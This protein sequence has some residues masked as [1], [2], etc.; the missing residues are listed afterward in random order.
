[1]TWQEV[2]DTAMSGETVY[3]G[4]EIVSDFGEYWVMTRE[5]LDKYSFYRA[6]SPGGELNLCDDIPEEDKVCYIEADGNPADDVIIYST[7]QEI[8]DMM[9]D[10]PVFVTWPQGE[11]LHTGQVTKAWTDKNIYKIS[12]DEVIYWADG[13]TSELLIEEETDEL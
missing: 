13:P 11:D 4:D 5:G 10:H 7:W 1:M 6:D 12:I 9:Q 2:C 3:I 8:S